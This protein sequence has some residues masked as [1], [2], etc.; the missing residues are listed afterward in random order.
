MLFQLSVGVWTA[1]TGCGRVHG[2]CPQQK[3]V[4]VTEVEQ[5]VGLFLL[6]LFDFH[7]FCLVYFIILL[8]VLATEVLAGFDRGRRVRSTP[9][10]DCRD[11]QTGWQ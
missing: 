1:A 5:K 4:V 6:G 2:R 3:T 8:L 11:M 10:L 9:A 7:L